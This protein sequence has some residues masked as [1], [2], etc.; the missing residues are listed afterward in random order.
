FGGR[1]GRGAEPPS[2]LLRRGAV[3]AL[4]AGAAFLSALAGGQLPGPLLRVVNSQAM[5]PTVRITRIQ[6]AVSRFTSSHP[7][8]LRAASSQSVATYRE[9]TC[10]IARV[11][12]RGHSIKRRSRKCYFSSGDVTAVLS[13]AASPGSPLLG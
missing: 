6:P 5:S 13:R 7:I 2:E 3:G 12:R 4:L 8:R 11:A 9:I 1:F 10:L